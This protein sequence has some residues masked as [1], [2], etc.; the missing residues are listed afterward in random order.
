MRIL[1][2]AVPL[3]I[4]VSCPAP[5]HALPPGASDSA[6]CVAGS[7]EGYVICSPGQRLCVRNV[8]RV[9]NAQGTALT[10]ERDCGADICQNGQCVDPGPGICL[11][12]S[13]YC[14]GNT[15]MQ[16]N[17]DGSATVDSGEPCGQSICVDGSCLPIICQAGAADCADA[18]ARTC[19]ALG[20]GYSVQQPCSGDERCIDGRCVVPVRDASQRDAIAADL[21]TSD[22]ARPDAAGHDSSSSDGAAVDRA[23]ADTSRPDAA[24]PDRQQPDT[25]GP[26]C[27]SDGNCPGGYCHPNLHVCL[28]LPANSCSSSD[29]CTGVIFPSFCDPLTR[30]C[31]DACLQG[32]LCLGMF[33]GTRISCI[34]G[35]CY[36]CQTD[37]ECPGTRC[38]AF[39][40]LCQACG[41]DADCL[42]PDWHCDTASGAC[43]QCLD[44]SH[45]GVNQVC[46]VDEHRCVECNENSDCRDGSKPICGKSHSCLPPCSDE[47][48]QDQIRCNPADLVPPIS[49][50]QCAD[51]DDDPCLEWSTL[52]YSCGWHQTCASDQCVCNN[53]CSSGTASCDATTPGLLHQCA[54]D[55]D[56][57][58][59]LDEVW[60]DAIQDCRNGDCV[61]AINCAAGTRRCVS[62]SLTQYEVCTLDS[63]VDC[64]YWATYSCATNTTCQGA[65]TCR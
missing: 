37:G 5:E 33:D 53:E 19:N 22:H 9:C 6:V 29:Q 63:Y 25:G 28:A 27:S 47:C 2:V 44:T 35:G 7:C 43:H 38:D 23:S 24:L 65:G 18:V 46:F 14:D 58:W 4:L 16:C 51:H 30:T 49:M 17:S 32:I 62:G 60:C 42:D 8:L 57:C 21:A 40:W 52:A 3:F 48:S 64:N 50:L 10:T 26:S 12:D 59:Y 61:C 41:G 55:Y 54:Q 11:P 39:D 20:T 15:A 13:Q 45:C 34:A 1:I 56:G 31:I 36:Q